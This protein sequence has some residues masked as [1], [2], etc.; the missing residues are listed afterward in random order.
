MSRLFSAAHCTSFR[1]HPRDRA[2]LSA[3]TSM[4][5]APVDVPAA[6][7]A[8]GPRGEGSDV[9]ACFEDSF[10][11]ASVISRRRCRRS[12]YLAQTASMGASLLALQRPSSQLHADEDKKDI[13]DMPECP[14]PH[15][16]L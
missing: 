1:A 6:A 4:T 16:P 10:L 9:P 7:A 13:P 8:A 15:V 5:S 2:G 12:D 3:S 11:S 14:P